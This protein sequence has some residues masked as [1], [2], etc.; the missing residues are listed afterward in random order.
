MKQC[1]QGVTNMAAMRS[2]ESVFDKYGGHTKNRGMMP[3]IKG[4]YEVLENTDGREKGTGLIPRHFVTLRCLLVYCKFSIH[5][6]NRMAL[7]S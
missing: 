2:F 4:S 7:T 1:S 6:T 3:R 5:M